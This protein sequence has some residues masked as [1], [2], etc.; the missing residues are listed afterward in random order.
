MVKISESERAAVLT[1][2]Q[3]KR[4]RNLGERTVPVVRE[5]YISFMPTPGIIGPNQFVQSVPSVLISQ[6]GRRVLWRFRYHLPP[7]KTAEVI[8][9]YCP[10]RGGDVT[11]VH[12]EVRVTIMV[13]VP[14]VRAPA[15]ASHLHP[16]L[17]ADVLER[18]VSVVPIQRIA[19][20][21]LLVKRPDVLRSFLLKA[22]LR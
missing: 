22:L 18:P 14:R 5:G 21:V 4:P 9:F 20:R 1:E 3:S 12:V 11:V 8:P 10:L 17:P 2:V 7:E 6:R 16:G 15:R 13:E 19:S